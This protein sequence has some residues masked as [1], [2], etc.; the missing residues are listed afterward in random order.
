MVLG[1]VEAVHAHGHVLHQLGARR[2]G[3]SLRGGAEIVLMRGGFWGLLN[4]KRRDFV[5]ERRERRGG[6]HHELTVF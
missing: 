6:L 4:D 2:A 1:G 3:L 5:L